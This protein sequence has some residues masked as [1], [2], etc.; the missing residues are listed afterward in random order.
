[1]QRPQ[2]SKGMFPDGTKKENPRLRPPQPRHGLHRVGHR[3]CGAQA[4]P[5]R[6]ELRCRTV[7]Q[8]ESPDGV[9]PGALRRTRPRV[10]G[11]THPEGEK[12]HEPRG[13]DGA[14]RHASVAGPRSPQPGK[15]QDAPHRGRRR[16][17]ALDPALQRLRPEH[18]PE[19][20]PQPQGRIPHFRLPAGEDPGRPAHHRI[21]QRHGFP[22]PDRRCGLRVR[23]LPGAHRGHAA[24]QHH[25]AGRQPRGRAGLRD[26][27]AGAGAHRHGRKDASAGS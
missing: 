22:G 9:Y 21:R 11:R 5:G 3:L 25:R 1:M 12:L 14:P 17:S 18:A 10:R 6:C 4:G 20:R 2:E 7:R 26:R 13:H 24:G 8:R 16:S 27:E 19:D 15:L 23:G